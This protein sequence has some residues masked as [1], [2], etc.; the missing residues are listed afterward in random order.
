MEN[1]KEKAQKTINE[2][3]KIGKYPLLIF[4]GPGTG[5]SSTLACRVIRLISKKL[6]KPQNIYV[7]SF[8]RSSVQDLKEKIEENLKKESLQPSLI[9]EIPI[10]TAH[11]MAY[12]IVMENFKETG[13]QK[14]P[15]IGNA[16]DDS[17]I[18]LDCS[19]NKSKAESWK[20]IDEINERL[21]YCKGLKQY[22][23]YYKFKQFYGCF[24]FYEITRK[25][26]DIL[27]NNKSVRKDY[28]AKIRFLI[29]DE[30]QDL[31]SADQRLIDYLTNNQRGLTI[32]GDDD[33]SI[34]KFRFAYPE[35]I[36]KRKKSG[37]YI[38]KEMSYSWR[39]PYYICWLANNVIKADKD[40]VPT[41]ISKEPDGKGGMLCPIPSVTKSLNKETEWVAQQVE[42]NINFIKTNSERRRI[43]KRIKE[44]K[45]PYTILILA[46]EPN[47]LDDL[48]EK[49]SERQI[50]FDVK[51]HKILANKKNKLVYYALKFIDDDTNN[52]TVRILLNRFKKFKKSRLLINKIIK[53]AIENEINLFSALQ[54]QQFSSNSD[55]KK[56]LKL[57]DDLLKIKIDEEFNLPIILLKVIKTLGFDKSNFL[58]IIKIAE[59]SSDL[60]DFLDKIVL[61]NLDPS[62]T[63]DKISIKNKEIYVVKLMTIHSS[64]GLTADEVF[65]MG[66][67]NGLLPKNSTSSEIQDLRLFYVAITRS[68]GRLYL[69]YVKVRRDGGRKYRVA[70]GKNIREISHFLKKLKEEPNFKR[71]IKEEK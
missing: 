65:I 22:K 29:V 70:R 49:L 2:I 67:E 45:G 41:I 66:L 24:N 69:S 4:A 7:L 11:G 9:E 61:E 50:N 44:G 31:N 39:C 23:E 3:T 51:Q 38:V 25:A 17:M 13:W 71:Y 55:V 18:F 60:K 42:K 30:Y 26:I 52:F 12:N 16:G 5:K 36:R 59:S 34:Y 10:K 33:Q 14:K 53:Y 15:T 27:K 68:S 40:R 35:G 58:D 64:K 54:D 32:C 57:L 46:T 6:V 43:E 37:K 56:A 63:I 19:P 48:R 1:L 21:A 8:S 47:V 62:D 20:E 28:L